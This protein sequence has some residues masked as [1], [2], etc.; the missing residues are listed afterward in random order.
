MRDR[1]GANDDMQDLPHSFA[2]LD[3]RTYFSYVQLNSCH[4]ASEL[5]GSRGAGLKRHG[6]NPTK[7]KIDTTRVGFVGLGDQGGGIAERIYHQGWQLTVWARRPESTK[8]FVAGGCAV[9]ASRH[10]LGAACDVIGI[11]VRGDAD[12]RSVLLGDEPGTGVLDGMSPGSVVAVHSTIAPQ[13]AVALEQEAAARG[14]WLVDA[15]VSGG[16]DGALAGRMSI[17]T[18]GAPEAVEAIDPILSSFAANVFHVGP[19][20]AGMAVKV[21]NNGVSFGNMV[22]VVEALRA[23]DRLGFDW[24]AV[25]NVMQ[26][27]SGGSTGLDAI[28]TETAFAKLS[29]PVNN[30][31]KD[32]RH[33]RDMLRRGGADDKLLTDIAG[34]AT[35]AIQ[36]FARLKKETPS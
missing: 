21:I 25:A 9:A 36:A 22:I 30:I 18:G 1:L 28:L 32:V 26:S 20:G 11:C 7:A 3:D 13:T 12:V 19:I 14:I 24:Q 17:I 6:V 16:R 33:L 15:A 4:Q 34:Q 35:E 5:T 2:L 23:A 29:S 10:E 31:Q 8:P 27:S